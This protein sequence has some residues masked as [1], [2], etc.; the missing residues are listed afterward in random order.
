MHPLLILYICALSAG[1]LSGRVLTRSGRLDRF[2]RIRESGALL[3]T[4]LIGVAVMATGTSG[5]LLAAA[6][7]FLTGWTVAVAVEYRHRA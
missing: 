7:W 4:G 1:L 5:G 3:V 6:G 2:S